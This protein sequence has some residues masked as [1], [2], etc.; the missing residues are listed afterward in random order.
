MKIGIFG[1]SGLLGS[2]LFEKGLGGNVELLPLDW[3]FPENCR[4]LDGIINLAGYSID[5][6]W[7]QKNFSLIYESRVH[8]AKKIR[9]V[10]QE[11]PLSFRPKIWVNASATGFYGDRGEEVLTEFSSKGRGILSNLCADWEREVLLAKSLGIQ[12]ICFRFGMICSS[13]ARA[14][15]KLSLLSLP[16]FHFLPNSGNQ[17]FPWVHIDDVLGILR[18]C[19]LKQIEGVVNVI[20]PNSLRLKEIVSSFSSAPA[21]KISIPRSFLQVLLGD[22]SQVLTASSKVIPYRMQEENYSFSFPSLEKALADLKKIS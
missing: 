13:R 19:Y 10:L 5:R 12:T 14:W 9:E 20:S 3:R 4:G 15:R 18:F 22:F 16:P 21:L 6:R 11:I 8:F 17:W 2:Y 7:N 1:F